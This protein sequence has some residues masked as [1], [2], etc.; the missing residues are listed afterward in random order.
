MKSP[1][2]TVGKVPWRRTRQPIP[3]FLPGESH[4]QRSLVGYSSR[5]HKKSHTTEQLILMHVSGTRQ[6]LSFSVWITSFR[7]MPSRFTQVGMTGTAWLFVKAECYAILCCSVLS[8]FH[9]SFS[10]L[11]RGFY[12]STI[13]NSALMNI[14]MRI[15]LWDPAFSFLWIYTQK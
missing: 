3:V 7:V 4:G 9:L 14:G 2:C 10:G 1:L 15:S 11:I 8:S 12:I 6:H 5:G 13:V